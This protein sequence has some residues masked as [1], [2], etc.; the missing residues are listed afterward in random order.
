VSTGA[1][2]SGWGCAFPPAQPQEHYWDGFY[3][4]GVG[5]DRWLRRVFMSAGCERRHTVFDPTVEDL[6]ACSTGRRMERYIA[7]ALPLATGAA[8]AALES[9]GVAAT[10]IG[11][12]CVASCTGYATPG[13]DVALAEALGAGTGLRRMLLGHMGCH[14]AL[15]GLGA[16]SEYASTRRRPAL[17]VC[18]EVCSLHAQPPSTDLEQVVAHALFSDGAAALVVAPVG[19][20]LEVVDLAAATDASAAGHLRW[21]VTDR[22]FRMGLARQLPDAVGRQVGPLVDGLLAGRGLHR[23]DVAGWAV[24]PG[25]P[26]VL[27][28]V[29][30]RLGLDS[31]RLLNS[32]QVLA[33]H[34]NCSSPT[35]LVVLDRVRTGLAG[36]GGWVVA[37][38]FGPGLTLYGVLLRA[39]GPP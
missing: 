35:I 26:R 33:E 2:V 15:P 31:G 19:A 28:V 24:H 17:L 27:Q 1:V 30:D 38:A 23:D 12:L 8:V 6:S 37:L 36:A 5:G 29:A 21:E 4:P 10:E 14:A 11:L 13:L 9:A 18:A 34:G 3:G 20:G 32:R 39:D 25:G 16:A 22:G 7:A